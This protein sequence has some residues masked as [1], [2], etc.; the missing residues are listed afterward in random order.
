MVVVLPPPT[1]TEK[2]S[3]SSDGGPSAK[4]S[5]VELDAVAFPLVEFYVATAAAGIAATYGMA[6]AS[7]TG[8]ASIKTMKEKGA[9]GL[10]GSAKNTP[11]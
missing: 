8:S 5:L 4:S 9:G 11:N 6:A 3:T 2:T 10:K 1:P 7:R